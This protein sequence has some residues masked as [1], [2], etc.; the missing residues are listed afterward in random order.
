MAASG[1]TNEVEME[2][3]LEHDAEGNGISCS[4]KRVRK[5]A[6]HKQDCKNSNQK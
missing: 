4:Q 2:E 5:C 3:E 6:I 1:K